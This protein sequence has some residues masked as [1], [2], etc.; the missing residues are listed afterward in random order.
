MRETFDNNEID[1][2]VVLSRYEDP[3]EEIVEHCVKLNDFL[4][5]I[6]TF[7]MKSH[8]DSRTLFNALQLIQDFDM[9]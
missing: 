1:L 6:V 2:H 4:G 9:D 7:Y 5:M 8:E 3:E